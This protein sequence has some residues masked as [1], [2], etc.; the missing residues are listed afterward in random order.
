MLCA[1]CNYDN[2]A[3]ALF[4]VKCGTKVENRCTTCNT[5]NPAGANFCRKCGAALRAVA[6]AKDGTS[7]V[8]PL[9]GIEGERRHL[10]ILFCDLVGSTEMQHQLDPEESREI[11]ASYQR[12]A[13]AS[14]KRFD[15][16]VAKFLGD[17]VMAYFGYPQA[18][19]NDAERAVRAGLAILDAIN[20]LN[21]RGDRPKLSARIGIHTG[22]VVVG[23]GGGADAD[24]F[25]DAPN[26]ASRVQT[27]AEPGTVVITADTHRLVSGMFGVE[28]RGAH[29]LKGIAQPVELYRVVQPSSVRGRLHAG[30]RVLT[31]F[32]GREEELRLLWNRW[33]R[34]LDGEGQV[35]LIAGEA[36]I[37]KSRLVEQFHERLAGTPHGWVECASAPYFQNTP[38]YSVADMLQQGFA[39]RGDESDEE[40][41]N[42]LEL[43]LELSGLKPAE[44]V[45]LIA[46]LLNLPV[47][48]KYPP[49]L[50]SP[51]QQRKRLM[52]ALAA[53]TL[54]AAKMQ[55]TV[56]VL[57]DLHWVDPSTMEL[58]QILVDQGATAPL[59]LLFTARPEFRAPWPLHAHHSQITLN[60]LS[61]RQ[62]REMVARVSSNAG[63]SPQA[64]EAVVKRTTGVPLFVEELTRTVLEGGKRD[65]TQE[66]PA[67]LRD[68]LMARLDRLGSAREVA[69]IASVIGREF[70]YELLAE[71]SGTPDDGLQSALAKLSEAELIYA[72]G[73]PP[74]AT[75]QFKHALIQDAAYEALL[76]TRRKELHRRVARAIAENFPT[77]A[78]SQPEVLARHCTEGGEAES[79][80]DAW[81][82]AAERAVERGAY[83]E[84]ERHYRQ[85]LAVLAGVAETAQRDHRELDLQLALSEVLVA[86]KGIIGPDRE[87]AVS[88]AKA[89]AQKLDSSALKMALRGQFSVA[90]VHGRLNDAKEIADQLLAAGEHDEDLGTLLAGHYF[91]GVVCYFRGDLATAWTQLSRVLF[92]DN[93]DYSNVSV[94]DQRIESRMLAGAIAILMGRVDAGRALARESIALAERLQ[95]PY[96]IAF[97]R[98]WAAIDAVILRQP[99]EA[100]EFAQAVIEQQVSAFSLSSLAGVILGWSLTQ[101]G[102][103]GDGRA[104]IRDRFAQ[105]TSGGSE[106]DINFLRALSAEADIDGGYFEN[107]EA[108]IDEALCGDQEVHKPYL[109]WLRG[110]VSLK[111]SDEEK[112]KRYFAEALNLAHRI[113]A[114]LYELRAATSLA[115]LLAKQGKRDEARAMLADIYNWFTEGFDT[116]DL[117]EAKALL[118]E[119]SG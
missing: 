50:L 97:S 56:T 102:L 94:R 7:P 112:A 42:Q 26:L 113:G 91:Q 41:L 99:G 72:R 82:R 71:V 115:R 59:F 48:E 35:V 25:G 110:N 114:K 57:E 55:P 20:A 78:E 52:A 88:R 11:V 79:A 43:N 15:G 83:V 5:A 18:H 4:C 93:G 80:I 32:V 68:S 58:L 62:T 40:K 45:P 98:L 34:V 46:P 85:A 74:E 106:Y 12:A 81:R 95:M 8:E 108:M 53:W 67:T 47:P 1:K 111:V 119:L 49:L 23:T 96:E 10:T 118:D 101:R 61:D 3:D 86:S 104:L 9:A 31:P 109:L 107:A 63:L 19:D 30:G 60:R 37:G 33:E 21:G 75:Y 92:L 87:T 6:P 28:D 100:A 36:G 13:A 51:E 69:Q 17:G 116:A 117:K 64:V 22:S 39:W 44:A 77:I 84:A 70:S 66:I 90:I 27:A 29:Q 76:K 89:L 73:I 24:I 103:G 16:H 14:V 54:G 105:S 65:T 38:F 2:P